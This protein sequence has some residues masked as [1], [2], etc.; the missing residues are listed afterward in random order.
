MT[1]KVV[2]L[3]RCVPIGCWMPEGESLIAVQSGCY[4]EALL[5]YLSSLFYEVLEKEVW[6]QS[7]LSLHVFAAY[8]LFISIT[9]QNLSVPDWKLKYYCIKGIHH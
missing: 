8:H 3:F 1:V 7:V 6:G 5:G 2:F 9:A 4:T